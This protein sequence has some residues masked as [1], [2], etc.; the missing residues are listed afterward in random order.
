M[1]TMKHLP[2]RPPIQG[3]PREGAAMV[4]MAVVLP[5]FVLLLMGVIEFGRGMMVSNMVVNAAREATRMA[6]LTGS[7]NTEVTSGVTSFLQQSL[8]VPPGDVTTTITITPATGN[9]DPNN[10]LA[11]SNSRDLITVTVQVPFSKVSLLPPSYMK[12]T[13]I[14]GQSA[15]RHE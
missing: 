8:S 10:S 7:T 1:R 2:P 3:R 11:S 9:P 4:E 12:N 5:V 15:M 6:V 14:K 13:L